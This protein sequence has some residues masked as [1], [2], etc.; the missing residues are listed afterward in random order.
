MVRSSGSPSTIT[1]PPLATGSGQWPTPVVVTTGVP[2][3]SDSAQTMP[4]FS[5]I[6][7]SLH[8]RQVNL[9]RD[10]IPG[11]AILVLFFEDFKADPK[12]VLRKCLM[13]LKLELAGV[14]SRCR[15]SEG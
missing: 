12:A 15:Q 13:F 4:R 7:N 3:A 1:A 8:S 11:D 6:D 14:M 10:H 9:Y 2:E 5:C